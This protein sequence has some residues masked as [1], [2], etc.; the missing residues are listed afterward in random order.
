MPPV[1]LPAHV[2]LKVK[3]E[4]VADT[5]VPLILYAPTVVAVISNPWF[6]TKVLATVTVASPA[7]Q[8]IDVIEA[9]RQASE[10]AKNEIR[11]SFLMMFNILTQRM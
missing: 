8:D 11:V 9:A 4:A 2:A 7:V 6:A 5:A 1:A 3:F 10:A